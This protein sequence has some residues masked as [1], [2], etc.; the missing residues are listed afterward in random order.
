MAEV[1]HKGWLFFFFFYDS[2][3][4]QWVIY[5]LWSAGE[6][7]RALFMK[8]PKSLIHEGGK[9]FPSLQCSRRCGSA[10]P[11]HG[12]RSSWWLG[13]SW[14]VS[15]LPRREFYI[16]SQCNIIRVSAPA[17]SQQFR[18]KNCWEASGRQTELGFAPLLYPRADL[19]CVSARLETSL[20]LTRRRG[21]M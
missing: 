16:L 9:I 17:W 11:R 2:Q 3:R 19:C 20:S 7:K 6:F 14:E 12:G 13:P 5:I 21:W 15:S 4:Y 10:G 8:A 1:H 18:G